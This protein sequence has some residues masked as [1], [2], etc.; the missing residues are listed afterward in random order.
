M[1]LNKPRYLTKSRFKLA[2]NCPTKLFYT[3]KSSYENT[4]ETDT[5]LQG[6]A[7]G[8]FQVEELARMY[9]PE[10]MAILG[11]D[12]NY[13]KLA[14]RTAAL[15]A[16]DNVVI[17]EAA[18]LVEG[19]FIRVDILEKRGDTIKLIEVKA[20]S[21]DSASHVTF[22]KSKGS[23][24]SWHPY[25]YDVAFQKHVIQK[26]HPNW[27]IKPYLNLVDK[28]KQ[29]TVTGLNSHFKIEPNTELRTGV[30]V[31]PGLKKEDLGS[32]I[33]ALIS[34]DEEVNLILRDNIQEPERSFEETVA[35]YQYQYENDIKIETPIGLRC[36]GCEFKQAQPNDE[37]RSGFHE[38]WMTQLPKV[39]PDL[40]PLA[41]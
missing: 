27:K 24:G 17:F 11:E 1:I 35:F 4:S 22:I 31:T 3:R 14:E 10:G 23:L 26:C 34:V 20:K 19:L 36:K 28:S 2:L 30:V 29:T 32:S 9:F 13:S 40:K 38:C 12:W 16:Q 5:F 18:F 21:I 37:K 15:L 25:L 39:R 7:Q 8:G 41:V 6:L 33:L